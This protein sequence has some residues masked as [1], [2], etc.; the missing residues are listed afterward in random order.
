MKFSILITTKNRLSD[1]MISLNSMQSI[2]NRDDVEFIIC[3]DGSI[4]GTSEYIENHFPKIHLIKNE[5][6]KGYLANRNKMLNRSKAQYAISLDDD[7]HFLSKNPLE[8]IEKHF[9]ENSNCS[10]IAFRIFWGNKEPKSLNSIDKEER[11][12]GFVGCG[13][14]WRIATWRVIPNYPEWFGF[15]GEEDFASFQLFK[16]NLEVHYLPSVLIHHRVDIIARKKNNDYLWR[17]RRSYR[18]GLY[19]CLLFYPLSKLPKILIYMLWIQLKTRTFK[20]DFKATVVIFQVFGDVFV[21]LP[22]ILKQ[23]NR[24][25]NEEYRNYLKLTETKIYWKTNEQEL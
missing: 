4:D 16:N 6:S 15:F 20:G 24:F 12:K 22:K 11:V 8:E 7:A 13:H 23:S 10:L 21:N 5:V 14:A 17:L 19:L 18:S 9:E 2:I 25:T 1:L 3:D